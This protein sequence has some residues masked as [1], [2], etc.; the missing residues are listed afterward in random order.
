MKKIHIKTAAIIITLIPFVTFAQ[1]KDLKYLAKIITD[2]LYVGLGLIISLAVVTFVWNVYL[3]FFT[4]KDR[5]GA[6]TYVLY[7]VIGFFVILSFWGLV[8]LLRNSIVLDDQA[9][10]VLKNMGIGETTKSTNQ[11]G[12]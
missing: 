8:A 10:D 12:N 3:Y 5:E 6:A 7:S 9:P 2:Y 4:E 1:T 11:G